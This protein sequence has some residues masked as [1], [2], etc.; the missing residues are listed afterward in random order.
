M[1]FRDKSQNILGN[2][3]GSGK[4]I[5]SAQCNC[6]IL[7]MINETYIILSLMYNQFIA[8]LLVGRKCNLFL[9]SSI[10]YIN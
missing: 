7:L 1:I 10:E 6:R 4:F 9:M 5:S 3:S 8:Q 2:Y